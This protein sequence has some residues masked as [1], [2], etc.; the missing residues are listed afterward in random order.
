[1][2]NEV[3]SHVRCADLACAT[4]RRDA[5][6]P[7]RV[8]VALPVLRVSFAPSALRTPFALLV[9]VVLLASWFANAF[10]STPPSNSITPPP[11]SSDPEEN[12]VVI[13]FTRMPFGDVSGDDAAAAIR[14]WAASLAQE[15]GV[16]LHPRPLL[17]SSVDELRQKLEMHAFDVGITTAPEFFQLGLGPEDVTPFASSRDGDPYERYLLLVRSDS[18]FDDLAALRG[19]KLFLYENSRASLGLPWIDTL[20]LDASL[21]TPAEHFGSIRPIKKLSGTILPV[22]FGQADACLVT[23]YGFQLMIEM[24]PQVGQSLRILARSDPY[25]P[26]LGFFDPRMDPELRADTM[27]ALLVTPD[28]EAERQ[29]MTLFQV[30]SFG[31]VPVSTLDSARELL[32]RSRLYPGI[33][34][35]TGTTPALVGA[36]P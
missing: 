31:E 33:V 25:L 28:T 32:S 34:A 19:K 17:V 11:L 30:D 22:F 2:Q 24:N 12:A 14:A 35:R 23:D 3:T 6:F 36:T 13:G 20:L 15:T 9:L 10:G 29:I 8:R 18:G 4:A 1:M 5:R 26:A 27:Q 21:S 7:L 16:V